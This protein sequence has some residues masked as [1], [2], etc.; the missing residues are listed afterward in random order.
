L[1]GI[2]FEEDFVDG[3]VTFEEL[4]PFEIEID[5]EGLFTLRWCKLPALDLEITKGHLKVK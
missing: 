5:S 1:Q 3:V 4:S 2:S